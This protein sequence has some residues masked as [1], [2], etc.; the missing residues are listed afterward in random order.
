MPVFEIMV[1]IT[2]KYRGKIVVDAKSEKD[3][4]EYCRN[5]HEWH[6]DDIDDD[7]QY[8]QEKVP[9]SAM[10]IKHMAELPKHYDGNSLPWNGD[11]KTKLS[12]LL[13]A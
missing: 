10:E 1:E 9:I 6:Q 5:T 8:W 4:L 11:H 7:G 2:T 3:A 12:D 13:K